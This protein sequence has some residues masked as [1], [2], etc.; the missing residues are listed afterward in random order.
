MSKESKVQLKELPIQRVNIDIV[1]VSPLIVNAFSEKAIRM[2]EDK[3]QGKSKSSKHPPKNPEEDYEGAKHISPEGWEGFPAG[4]FKAAIVRGAKI[5]GLEMKSTRNAVFIVPD[6][7]ESQLIRIHGESRMR[8]DMVRIANGSADVRYRPEYPQWEAT[9][10]IEFNSGVI[11]LEYVY[12]IVS[13]GGYGV[14][15]GEM[16]PERTN[17]GYGRFKI[18]GT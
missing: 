12:Q 9:L 1:G 5:V 7:E 8:R 11:S 2:I 14:G 6:D 13:A 10:P 15:V 4:G 16:R 3:Q 17:F 18:K